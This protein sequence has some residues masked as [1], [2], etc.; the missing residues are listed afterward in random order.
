MTHI[1]KTFETYINEELNKETYLSAAQKLKRIGHDKR[2][3]N[4]KKYAN[5]NNDNIILPI[6]FKDNVYEI[7][8]SDINKKEF[9]KYEFLEIIDINGKHIFSI[10]SN[11]EFF[12]PDNIN[13]NS[14]LKDRK[15]AVNLHKLI[16]KWLSNNKEIL[17]NSRMTL[18]F[19]ERLQRLTVNNLYTE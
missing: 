8:S 4:L 16:F 12:W 5:R 10:S 11:G 6:T 13:K 19:N 3:D 17:N 15:S 1:K 7:N 18:S 14:K 2:S 9:N